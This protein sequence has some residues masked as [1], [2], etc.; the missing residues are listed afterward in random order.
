MRVYEFANATGVTGDAVLAEVK[1]IRGDDSATV[2]SGLSDDEESLLR[3]KFPPVATNDLPPAPVV[4]PVVDAGPVVAN[5]EG[6]VSPAVPPLT[7]PQVEAMP[8]VTADQIVKEINP[9]PPL[10]SYDVY[11]IGLPKQRVEALDESEAIC[12][13]AHRLGITDTVKYQ[14]Q[15]DKVAK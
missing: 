2:Q 6:A 1:K 8:K 3:E 5:Q 10:N 15:A 12:A 11:A 13:Y 14:F 4:P 7:P 9:L